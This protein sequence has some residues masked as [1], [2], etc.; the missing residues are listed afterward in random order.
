VLLLGVA[1]RAGYAVGIVYS[2]LVWG[3]GEGF[4][5]PYTSGATDI[6]PQPTDAAAGR[7]GA[8]C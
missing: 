7:L 8:S 2:L 4:G 3:V 6:A 5:G 1:R